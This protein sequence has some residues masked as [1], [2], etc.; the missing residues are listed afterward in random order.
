MLRQDIESQMKDALK[1][2]QRDL[3]ETLRFLYSAIKNAEIDLHRE[4]TDEDVV[5]VVQKQVKQHKESIEAFRKAGRTELA[6]KEEAELN[7]LTKYLPVQMSED[8]L[9]GIAAEVI[10]GLSDEDKKNFGKVMGAVMTKVK[11][12][13]DGSTVGRIVKELLA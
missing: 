11:G 13:T 3:L 8:E 6:A 4:A 1:S 9:R 12:K 10:S 7:V 2:G 5:T